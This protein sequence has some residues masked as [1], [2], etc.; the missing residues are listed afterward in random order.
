MPYKPRATF[1]NPYG[2]LVSFRTEDVL[3]PTALYLSP[4]DQLVVMTVSD[5]AGYLVF[6]Q[7]RL[8]LP[9]GEIKLMPYQFTP[10][11]TNTWGLSFEAPPTEGYILTAVC[12]ASP[13][14]QGQCFVSAQVMR[15]APPALQSTGEMLLQGYPTLSNVL[16]YPTGLLTAP[17]SGRGAFL[18]IT[19]PNQTGANVVFTV[20]QYTL[21]R[22]RSLEFI[23]NTSAAAAS[24]IV[25]MAL[26]DSA[27]VQIG[28]WPAPGSV[29]AS[30][31]RFYTFAP[32]GLSIANDPFETIGAPG[33]L[34]LPPQSTLTISVSGLD[35]A[36]TLTNMALAV[37]EWMGA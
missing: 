21:W 34:F 19:K 24:R 23:Y 29:A 7:T 11:A 33:E 16:S 1:D 17:F 18:T 14:Q 20:P 27:G 6:L 12:W 30:A 28:A 15:S 10:G 36:D 35:A 8:L 2:P 32:G 31:Q 9:T 13:P 37:E 5:A 22:L 25:V 26:K 4:E 3:P